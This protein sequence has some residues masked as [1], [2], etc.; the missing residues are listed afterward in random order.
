MTDSSTPLGP[1]RAE[2]IARVNRVIDHIERHL[3]E[4]LN[5]EALAGIANFSRY[6]FHRIF[7]AMVGETL[8]QFIQRLRV[9]RAAN[10][11]VVNP[12]T[13]I[14]AIALDCGFSS[15]ATFARAFKDAFGVTGTQWRE[16][17]HR[18]ICPTDRKICNTLGNPRK[19]PGISDCYLHPNTGNPTWS[20]A[21]S[22]E[23]HP[24]DATIE[25]HE[26]PAYDVAYIRHVG[27]YG[28]AAVV[29]RLVTTLRQWAMA[30]GL[31]DD[32]T[33]TLLVAH[34]SPAI[35]EPDKLRLSVCLTVPPGTAT[36][37]E[38][39]SMTIPGGRFAVGHF[40]IPTDRVAEAWNVMM[41][42]WLPSSG[43]QPDDRLCYEEALNDPRQ[44]PQGK[45][46]LDICVPVRPL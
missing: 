42:R 21:M 36:D 29:P 26:R 30:R 41:G 19:D 39:G 40:E 16:Q 33:K 43:Y 9:E 4:P 15:S 25:V 8:H 46:L 5:L 23:S 22:T 31:V 12:D 38:I 3:A 17:G 32:R 24:L 44:H 6:H 1:S 18:K 10:M 20:H 2:Y 14:T 7:G 37:G 13:S 11:L 45:I 28:Q 35:T 27:P 34:D